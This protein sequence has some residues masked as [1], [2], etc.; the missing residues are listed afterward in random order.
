LGESGLL[1]LNALES[2]KPLYCRGLSV[3]FLGAPPR[4]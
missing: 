1:W 4:T 3:F 2:E